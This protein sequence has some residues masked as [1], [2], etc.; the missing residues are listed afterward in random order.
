MIIGNHFL[1]V[2]K[3]HPS[4]PQ[5]FIQYSVEL[6]ESLWLCLDTLNDGQRHGILCQ[7]RLDWLDDQLKSAQKPVYLFMHHPP[8]EV[9]LASM[10]K[11]NLVTSD[12]FFKDN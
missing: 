8:F 11:D 10:D 2:F 4:M 9:G 6:E 7:E 3:A 5:G 12:L 1:D